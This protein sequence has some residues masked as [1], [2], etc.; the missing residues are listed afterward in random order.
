M[1]LLVILIQMQL[2]NVPN[3]FYQALF[4]VEFLLQKVFLMID[5]P[6]TKLK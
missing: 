3:K 5:L 1:V 2:L 6:V 4:A